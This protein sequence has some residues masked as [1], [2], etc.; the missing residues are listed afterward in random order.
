MT[1]KHTKAYELHSGKFLVLRAEV[2]DELPG[3]FKE[4]AK[5]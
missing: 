5:A 4:G 3:E 2:V 1:T